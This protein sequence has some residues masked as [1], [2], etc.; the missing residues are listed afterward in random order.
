MSHSVLTT[1]TPAA[2]PATTDP[3]RRMARVAGALS[4]STSQDTSWLSGPS[5]SSKLRVL[6]AWTP[7]VWSPLNGVTVPGSLP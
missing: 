2:A 1:H 5:A 7:A 4:L 6:M 3:L